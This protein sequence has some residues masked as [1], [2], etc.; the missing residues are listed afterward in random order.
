MLLGLVVVVMCVG[1]WL[2]STPWIRI[3]KTTAYYRYLDASWPGGG[4]GDVCGCMA[5]VRSSD[6]DTQNHYLLLVP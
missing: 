2:L 6:L 4:G 1:A 3:P 5:Y